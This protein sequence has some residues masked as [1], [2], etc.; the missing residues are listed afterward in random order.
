[1]VAHIR[2]VG[3]K[4]EVVVGI[5]VEGVGDIDNVIGAPEV[6]CRAVR[7]GVVV[8]CCGS[9]CISTCE[10][11]ACIIIT[12][13]VFYYYIIPSCVIYYTI[14]TTVNNSIVV[15]FLIS[16]I[17]NSYTIRRGPYYCVVG[18]LDSIL[19][20]IDS[21]IIAGAWSILHKAAINDCVTCANTRKTIDTSMPPIVSGN[22]FNYSLRF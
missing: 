3:R 19:S 6:V 13:V 7:A 10:I 4:A 18:D 20:Y 1:L 17:I 11:P 2:A 9:V 12:K 21:S 15:Y 5:V 8:P 16:I 14:A 22:S